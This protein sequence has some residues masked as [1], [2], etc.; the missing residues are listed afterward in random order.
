MARADKEA[1]AEGS[2]SYEPCYNFLRPESTSQGL[3]NL[4]GN[5]FDAVNNVLGTYGARITR[6]V[7]WNNTATFDNGFTVVDTSAQAR[8]SKTGKTVAVSTGG[9]VTRDWTGAEPSVA[10]LLQVMHTSVCMH[11]RA[12]VCEDAC[13]STRARVRS[14]VHWRVI[15]CARTLGDTTCI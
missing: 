6:P 9:T 3:N 11:G 14:I 13:A 4:V 12:S 15:V 8:Y 5:F 2:E 10:F 7:D 1:K